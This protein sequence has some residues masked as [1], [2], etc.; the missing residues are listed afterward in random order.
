MIKSK[1]NK[2]SK[3][4]LL[5]TLAVIVAL[6]ATASFVLRDFIVDSVAPTA[7]DPSLVSDEKVL[8]YFGEKP[9]DEFIY[10]L[11]DYSKKIE[12][13]NKDILARNEDVLSAIKNVEDIPEEYNDI[14][15]ETNE[16]IVDFF[17]ST[18][19]ISVKERL[20]ILEVKLC[21]LPDEIDGAY[22]SDFC[23]GK[24]IEDYNTIYIKKGYI[25]P[26][27]LQEDEEIRKNNI[28]SFVNIYVHET[29]HY[30]GINSDRSLM[31]LIEG[32]TEALTEDIL[33]YGGYEYEN[34]SRYVENKML[35]RQ[36]MIADKKLV[37]DIIAS[38]PFTDEFLTQRID[39]NSKLKISD[40]ITDSFKLIMHYPQKRDYKTVAQYF[41]TEYCKNFEL[42]DSEKLE[43]YKHF[44]VSLEEM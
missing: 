13:V 38:C 41:V 18:Y 21:D 19:S 35:A 17:E 2:K 11:S 26:D 3:K 32:M 1:T 15:S 20:S 16:L 7:P 4:V 8:E 39:S 44:I 5:I 30:L 23:D 28:D 42:T 37:A 43:I 31:Y 14:I 27:M 24:G 36:V 12:E 29:V 10:D 6:L 25:N 34:T 9:D 22:Y 40:K 33:T